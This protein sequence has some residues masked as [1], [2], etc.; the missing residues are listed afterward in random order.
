MT[1]IDLLRDVRMDVREMNSKLDDFIAAQ[2]ERDLDVQ[3]QLS[4]NK[5]LITIMSAGISVVVAGLVTVG[6]RF[7]A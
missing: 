7:F 6:F 5:T 2:H 1:Q 3:R 4:E